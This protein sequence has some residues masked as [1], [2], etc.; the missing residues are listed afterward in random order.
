MGR[1]HFPQQVGVF[2]LVSKRTVFFY[3]W[4]LV[5]WMLH[6]GRARHPAP[7]RE[8][9]VPDHLSGE[10]ANVGGWLTCGDMA[11]DSGAQFLAVAEHRLTSPRAKYIGHQLRKAGYQPVWDPACQD[12]IA[13][14]HAGVGGGQPGR[15]TFG[16]G[17]PLLPLRL[18]SSLSWEGL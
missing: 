3:F 12:Q 18:R 16:F 2:L 17:L 5:V 11:M 8:N 13:G 15:C 9:C 4:E 1:S 6:N 10:F 14:G 7:G